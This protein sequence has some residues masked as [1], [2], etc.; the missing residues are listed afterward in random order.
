MKLF[1]NILMFSFLFL[2]ES[3]SAQR[4]IFDINK[5]LGKGINFGNIFEAPRENEWGNPFRDDYPAKIKALGFN[6]IRIPIRWD[7]PERTL[8]TS[9]YTINPA[10][11]NRIKHVVDLAMKEGLMVIINMHHHD[12][13]FINPQSVKPRFLSQWQQIATFFKDYSDKLIFEVMNEPHNQLTPELWNVFFADALSEIRKTNPT[14]AVLL[15]TAD[16]GGVGGIGKLLPPTDSNI[17]VTVHYYNPF[18]FTHQGASWVGDQ[19]IPWLGTKW[20]DTEVDRAALQSEIQAVIDFSKKYNIPVHM[21]EF[22]AFDRADMASRV[23]WTT[24]LARY[25][26]SL[27]FSWA[28]WEWS[29]GFGIF[30]PS[31]NSYNQPLVDA[32]IKNPLPSPTKVLLT[33]VYTSNYTNSTDGWALSTSSGATGSNVSQNGELNITIS[34][35]GTEAWNVQLSKGGVRIEKDKTYKLTIEAKSPTN[36]SF[37]YY[38]GKA[39]D[40]W[41]S[42]SGYPTAQLNDKYQEFATVFN[43]TSTTDNMARIVLD[44]GS[45]LGNIQIKSIKLEEVILDFSSS[46]TGL[47][48]ESLLNIFPN[49]VLNELKFEQNLG[50]QNAILIFNKLGQNIVQFSNIKTNSIDISSIQSGE[51]F[52]KIMT[53]DGVYFSKFIKM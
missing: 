49:P 10:F 41:N 11:M 35:L 45:K 25:F 2:L 38:A 37:T 26:E 12:D 44:L 7:T 16:F 13:I 39:S 5:E 15:G 52:I 48:D 22:G 17:I 24:F 29:A 46:L 51:Y 9:P 47:D 34:R 23:R 53:T 3:L 14:R 31:N 28:Y 36:N 18:P 1:C 43:M 30:V 27:N 32:L 42:Y 6:H 33:P 40:P 21:G 50:E 20:N 8:Q 19:S 4:N